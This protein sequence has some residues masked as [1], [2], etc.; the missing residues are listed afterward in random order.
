MDAKFAQYR[1][2]IL[3]GS[4]V[5]TLL[6]L[7]WPLMIGSLLQTL[8]NVV[9]T[10]WLGKLGKEALAAPANTW[11]LI[12]LMISLGMGAA[13]AAVALVSQYV[14]AEKAEMA[15]KA[16][17]QVFAFMF[18][19]SSIIALFG[20]ILSPYILEF[21]SVPTVAF[22]M[23]LEY[24]QIIFLGIPFMFTMFAFSFILRGLGDTRTAVKI[25][26]TSV[27][28]NMILDP[29]LIFG[30]GFFPQWEVGGAAVATVISRALVG[31]IAVYLLFSGKLGIKL[32]KK[33]LKP[34]K[35]FI[36]KII[37]VGLPA[38]IGQSTVAFGFV[39]LMKF[40]NRVG[41]TA[42]G[43][44][45][46]GS[47]ITNLLFTVTGGITMAN[48]T[49][50]GQNLGAQQETRAEKS[51]WASIAIVFFMLAASSIIIFF[52]RVWVFKIFVNDPGVI[53]EGKNFI[54][55]FVFSLPFFSVF[56][57]VGSTF[58]GSGQTKY[59]M[60]LGMIRFWGLRIPLCYLFAF[61]MGMAATGIWIGMMISNIV[62]SLVALG[63][64]MTGR[65]KKTVI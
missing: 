36:K 62:G 16:A 44:Y 7:G 3:N 22:D 48:M 23:V 25:T 28:L 30:V 37:S 49:M 29:L 39:I 9:D 2:E 24:I 58:Q 50:I 33:Y 56:Q 1:D 10:F 43:A 38:S 32:E 13:V 34:E 26:G 42:I 35:A 17:T 40:V 14:G 46:I 59:Q 61:T 31:I 64:F 54:R 53:A 8:Y 20:I 55:I 4:I 57:T 45:T 12:W 65:W 21:M 60:I 47:R 63:F 6:M 41:L 5:R 51:V 27:I 18:F 11:P 15:N 19:I 52:S